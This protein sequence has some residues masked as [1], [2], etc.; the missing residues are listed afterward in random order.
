MNPFSKPKIISPMNWRTQNVLRLI[1]IGMIV[2]K[3]QNLEPV[4][5]MLSVSFLLSAFD[6]GIESAPV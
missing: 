4:I 1:L 3:H 5:D 2:N 6:I